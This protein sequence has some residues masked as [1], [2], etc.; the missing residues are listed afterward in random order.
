M[1]TTEPHL[2]DLAGLHPSLRQSYLVGMA[3]SI[4]HAIQ[5]DRHASDDLRDRATEFLVACEFVAA[6]E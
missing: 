4:C 3:K 2:S 1:I 5:R 6:A